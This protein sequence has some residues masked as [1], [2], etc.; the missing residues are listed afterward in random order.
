MTYELYVVIHTAALLVAMWLVHRFTTGSPLLKASSAYIFL[1][2][3]W[4]YKIVT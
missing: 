4:L 2:T 1:M 3:F